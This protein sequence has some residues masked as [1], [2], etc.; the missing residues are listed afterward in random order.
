MSVTAQ[1]IIDEA[2]TWLGTPWQHQGSL[3]GVGAD[4]AGFIEGVNINC[5][6][7]VRQAFAKDYRRR[8]DGATML[9]LLNE[10]TE[11]SDSETRLASIIAFHDGREPSVPRHL[12]FASQILPH[13]TY[14]IHSSE[15]MGVAEHRIDASWIKKIHSLWRIKG[16]V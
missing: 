2:R 1:Q 3:K 7:L 9:H 16:I 12:A 4:C 10:L 13:T 11:F 5:G 8:E 15:R 14:I 6:L